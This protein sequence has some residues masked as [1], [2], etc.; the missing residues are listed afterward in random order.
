LTSLSH[1]GTETWGR[2]KT[3]MLHR[4]THSV[5]GLNPI[6][7]GFYLFDA[8]PDADLYL[9]EHDQYR[10][11]LESQGVST[12]ELSDYI[13]ENRT[14]MDSLASLPYLN[15]SSV[16]SRMGRFYPRWA[17]GARARRLSSGKL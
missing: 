16:I 14:L 2:L 4:P 6:T 8:I 13:R 11:L 9:A 12:L 10:K 1:Y 7:R 17:G 3:A 5:Q 15:D